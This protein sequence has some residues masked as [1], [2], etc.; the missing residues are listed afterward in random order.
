MSSS[1]IQNRLE[2]EGE[3]E[4][5]DPE[6]V[7][8]GIMSIHLKRYDFALAY[9]K[10]KSVLD[11]ACGVGY[12]SAHLAQAALKVTGIDIDANAVAYG[13]DHYKL[14]NLTLQV[15]DVTQTRL[16]NS[17]FD[18]VSSFDTIEHLPDIPAYL[19]EITRVLRPDGTYIVSTPQVPHTNPHPE[20]P[21]HTIEFSR[22]NFEALLKLYFEEV[23]FYGQ[24]RR[25]SKIH[26]WI[27]NFLAKTGLRQ[28]L[29]RL[30]SLR[31]SVNKA[32]K[33]STFDDMSMDD[34]IITKEN[35]E[36][37]SEIVAVCRCPRK[38]TP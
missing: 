26:Y 12:G 32:L 31:N 25:Q 17:E 27:T 33:T 13:Q 20:N 19:R 1:I 16:S 29:P 23:E 4:R 37:A 30:M 15:A 3:V 34:I 35:I 22:A 38:V 14:D 9:C 8:Q 18:V 7:P 36:R 28:R 21:Y 24:Q 6:L 5:I 11:A 10:G 2:V